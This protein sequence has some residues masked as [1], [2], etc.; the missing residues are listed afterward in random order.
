MDIRLELVRHCGLD[1][2]V[3]SGNE[4]SHQRDEAAARGLRVFAQPEYLEHI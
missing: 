4:G 2:A 3:D 1:I